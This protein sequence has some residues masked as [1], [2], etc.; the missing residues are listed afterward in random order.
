MA[1]YISVT[2]TAK[3]VRQELKK[4][5]PGVVFSVRSSSYSMGASR[6][7]NTNRI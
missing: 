3:I 4:H 5:F 2:D 1:D 6:R 7:T